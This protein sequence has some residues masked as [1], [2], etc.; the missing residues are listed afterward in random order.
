M[1]FERNLHYVT[2]LTCDIQGDVARAES[3]VIG[4]FLDK[5]CKKG[6]VPVVPT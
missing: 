3:Y 2:M 5:D 6:R 4:L 1:L